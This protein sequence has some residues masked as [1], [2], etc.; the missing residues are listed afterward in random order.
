[1]MEVCYGLGRLYLQ[2]SG[3]GPLRLYRL[4]VAIS[5]SL[6]PPSAGTIPPITVLLSRVP[7]GYRSLASA[8]TAQRSTI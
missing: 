1:M 8:V 4:S 2:L 5:L 3:F 6:L 7:R